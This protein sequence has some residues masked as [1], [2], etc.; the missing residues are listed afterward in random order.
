MQAHEAPIRWAAAA[1][2]G[3]S[4]LLLPTTTL[5]APHAFHSAGSELHHSPAFSVCSCSIL[6]AG[7]RG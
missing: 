1:L 7:L 2:A 6:A 5:N 3:D 4:L